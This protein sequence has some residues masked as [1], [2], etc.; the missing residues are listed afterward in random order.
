[1]GS[2]ICGKKNL[3]DHSV[4]L[5]HEEFKLAG[6]ELFKAGKYEE[7]IIQYTKAIKSN[8]NVSVYFSNRALCFYK[9][10]NYSNSFQDGYSALNL[11]KSNVKAILMCIKSK[12]SQTLNPSSNSL[13]LFEESLSFFEHLN[14]LPSAIY[15]D[16][17]KAHFHLLKTKILLLKPYI[18][19]TH[20]KTLIEKY[21]EPFIPKNL[22]EKLSK[23]LVIENK[24]MEALVCPLTLEFFENPVAISSGYTYEHKMV[25][26]LVNNNNFHDPLN[27]KY[28]SQTAI[29]CNKAVK[30]AVLW[31]T[32]K[33]PE[34]VYMSDNKEL[35]I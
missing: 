3:K 21:Y 7:A 19:K 23:Y 31:Y 22:Y 32:E 28:F 33:Y 30:D 5:S 17:I 35:E 2:C 15:T 29:Y 12:V 8:P 6:N 24:C 26:S 4:H 11:D 14:N 20:K 27:R 13:I 16:L 10:K 9:L 34:I 25:K 18:E 1:M